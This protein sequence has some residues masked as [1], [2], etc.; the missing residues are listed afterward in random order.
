MKTPQ[1]LLIA[2][3]SIDVLCEIAGHGKKYEANRFRTI[4]YWI[5]LMSILYIGNFFAN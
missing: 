1:I 4:A 2:F 3:M 5:V